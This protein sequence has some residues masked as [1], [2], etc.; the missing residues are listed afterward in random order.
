MSYR[1]LAVAV[2]VVAAILAASCGNRPQ[3]GTPKS[4]SERV[5]PDGGTIEDPAGT[6]L[7]IPAGALESPTSITVTTFD[8]ASDF[9]A[10]FGFPAPTGVLCGVRLEPDG[11]EFAEPV[12]LSL[13][14]PEY[15]EPGEYSLCFWNEDD[16]VWEY[17][18]VA[19]VAV[20]GTAE[21][22][23]TH[24]CSYAAFDLP[25]SALEEFGEIADDPLNSGETVQSLG[26]SYQD[27]LEDEMQSFG[28]LCQGCCYDQAGFTVD[29][30]YR[31]EE[32]TGG[33]YHGEW[34]DKTEKSYTISYSADTYAVRLTQYLTCSIQRMMGL[35]AYET[36]LEKGQSTDLEVFCRCGEENVA[37]R[38]M[39]LSLSGPGRL[40]ATSVLTNAK[41]EATASYTATEEG[42]AVITAS[43][44]G[45]GCD[46]EDTWRDSD[47][48]TITV[49]SQPSGTEKWAGVLTFHQ[50]GERHAC[51]VEEEDCDDYAETLM[52]AIEFDLIVN[53]T[54]DYGHW[55]SVAGIPC[56]KDY[57]CW[58]GLNAAATGIATVT[59]T[60]AETEFWYYHPDSDLHKRTYYI[61]S[62][63]V[64]D[65]VAFASAFVFPY[66]IL[67]DMH[68][69]GVAGDPFV[70]IML[71]C[72]CWTGTSSQARAP[73]SGRT[74]T[75]SSP[76]VSL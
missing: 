63:R 34:G 5:G 30:D 60:P 45:C 42:T 28:V 3:D 56:S 47:Q 69:L 13:P 11:L 51:D 15:L 37:E 9:G 18:A 39:T 14:T 67:F 23:I 17:A 35:F 53:F 64:D 40:S 66:S 43:M 36:Q 1:A 24:F 46:G 32:G 33:T 52:Y 7:D 48:E 73:K 26:E 50:S 58:S 41:G 74:N 29:V 61:E 19:T 68:S 31:P 76:T 55:D 57:P 20:S 70:E 72:H 44:E 65:P 62:E 10:A 8:Q 21:A 49:G 12:S 4:Y 22:E 38:E 6:T 54:F 71:G 25:P 59:V 16:E 75:F 2:V 27:Y